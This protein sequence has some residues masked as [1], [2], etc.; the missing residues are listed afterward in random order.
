MKSVYPGN[1]FMI[2]FASILLVVL[3]CGNP[4]EEWSEESGRVQTV[5]DVRLVQSEEGIRDW[6]LT[7]DSAVYREEDSLLTIID[8]NIVFYE[9]DIPES[10]L[11]SDSGSSDLVDGRTVLWGNVFAENTEGRTLT[12]DLLNWSDSM[13]TFQTD[14]L[15][16]FMIP[17]ST[18]T[19]TLQGRGV[20]FDTGLSALGDI[21]VQES[22]TAVTTGEVP[23]DR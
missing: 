21:T 19:T 7:G 13:G 12:T 2:C 20:V 22:F 15:V 14:C 11:R 4:P 6:M 8:V 10:F 9:N 5:A 16:T 3:A 18:G 17:E 1:P 23:L